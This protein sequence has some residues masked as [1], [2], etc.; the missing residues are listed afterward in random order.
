MPL[1]PELGMQRRVDFFEFEASLDYRVSSRAARASEIW[2]RAR[3][4]CLSS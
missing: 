4:I 3:C 1:I 2:V